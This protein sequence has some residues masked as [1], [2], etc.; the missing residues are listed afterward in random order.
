[1][2]RTTKIL[3]MVL[4]VCMLMSM[5]AC[6][7]K[8]TQETTAP[9]TTVPA[10]EET[11]E[12]KETV[13]SNGKPVILAVSFGTS[14][15]ESRDATI[16]A[17]EKAL[18]DA[19]PDYEVRRAFTSQIIIDKLAERDN[20]K[21]DNV[22][23]AMDRL[24]ADGVK[25]VIVQ[26]T[27]V[28]SGFEYDDVAKE[29]SQYADKFE[30]L[31]I[32]SPLLTVDKDYDT[33]TAALAEETAQYNGEDTAIVFMGHGTEHRANAT[34]AK[35]QQH[36]AD[37]GYN[38][39]FVGTVEATP[40]LEDVIKLAKD[41]GAKK[42]VLLPL[43]VVAGDHANNDM[44]GDEEGSWKTEFQKAGFEVECVLKGM[45][46]YEK[47]RAMYVDHAKQAMDGK[48]PVMLAVSFGTSYNDSRDL[49]IGAVE[50]ALQQAYP[51]YEVRRAFTSQIIIDKLA[52]RDN[53]K[54]DNV[55][56]AMDR[57]VED[58]VKN[59]IVQPTH[60]MA[61]YEY[62]DVAKEIGQYAN[63]FDS[64]KMGSALLITDEDYDAVV[65]VL[66]EE[67]KEYAAEDAAI[68]WMGH[69]TE[70][71]SN[72]TYAKL[73]E[74]ITAAGVK[75]MFVG[76]VEATPALEDVI[77]LSKDAGVK[78][79]TLLPLMIV[80][81][82][83]ANNDMAGDEEGSWKTEFQKAGFEVNC[84]LKGLGQYEGIRTQI[85]NHAAEAETVKAA[86]T[87]DMLKDGTYD[88]QVES[89]SS[90]FKITDC[91]LTVAEGKMTAVMTMS[92]HGYGKVFMG[93][94]AEAAKA[95]EGAYIPDVPNEEGKNTFTVPVE[96]LDVDVD[97][98]AW[99][100][101]K[102]KWYDRTL[103]FMSDDLPAE[104]FAAGK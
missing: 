30:K 80:A 73:Q 23:Q 78:K 79:V 77:K 1:M 28:M 91:K 81:G 13:S 72:A 21:I 39:Y 96:A 43:M 63:K 84:V 3:A 45:G 5:A 19:Y 69:G 38:N 44:A 101:K 57:L 82:D 51:Q 74:K 29:V 11:T 104:A 25:E 14:F 66:V 31:T 65:K 94:E 8:D 70:H 52:E 97:C 2:K 100:K 102:E 36:F 40:T 87:A 85:V 90:M 86:V 67:T 20:L 95:E 76:T 88:I 103:V 26:P 71:A 34:Y 22:K 68:V 18:Q 47:V 49:T 83:H 27:H 33:L 58:G 41:S 92:G 4:C 12:P 42:V 15:N 61:G 35:M 59:V 75:N 64:L 17:V 55:K 50:K 46:Q 56:Q 37:A 9:E 98:A 89:S 62:D 99:S 54:I 10:A 32:G 60:V 16:G 48:K 6:G 93:T 24:A 7:K 53:L